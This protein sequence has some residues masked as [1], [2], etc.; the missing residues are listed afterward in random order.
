[1]FWNLSEILN[2]V[3]LNCIGICNLRNTNMGH[4][5]IFIFAIQKSATSLRQRFVIGYCTMRY[6]RYSIQSLI[7]HL[8]IILF[9]AELARA[10]TMECWLL[11]KLFAKLA[12]IILCHVLL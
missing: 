2:S 5:V 4:T 6:L 8:F 1:M 10:R 12:E 7:Q 9:R 3:F 11:K